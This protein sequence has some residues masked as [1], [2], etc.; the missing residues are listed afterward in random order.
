MFGRGGGVWE[1]KEERAAL[2][3][4]AGAQRAALRGAQS[5][6]PGAALEA[7]RAAGGGLVPVLRESSGKK[8]L[9]VLKVSYGGF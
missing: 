3:D 4:S 8:V 2:C 1:E 6:G 5:A 9:L 7:A